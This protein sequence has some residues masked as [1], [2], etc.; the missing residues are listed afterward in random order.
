[1]K[2]GLR[3]VHSKVNLWV[4]ESS[5]SVLYGSLNEKFLI[6]GQESELVDRMF[7]KG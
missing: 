6:L 4:A 2:L 3:Q 1:M 5:S 7:W